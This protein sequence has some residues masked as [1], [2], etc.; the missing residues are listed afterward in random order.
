MKS[1]GPTCVSMLA[2]GRVAAKGRTHGCMQGLSLRAAGLRVL[3][4][5]T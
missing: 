4:G 5:E 3:H 2:W 1:N